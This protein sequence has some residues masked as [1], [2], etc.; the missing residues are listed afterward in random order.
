LLTIRIGSASVLRDRHLRRGRRIFSAR[1]DVTIT[2][3]TIE[4]LRNRQQ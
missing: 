4:Q 1:G 3:S 2:N